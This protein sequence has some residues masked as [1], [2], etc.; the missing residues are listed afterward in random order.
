MAA[1]KVRTANNDDLTEAELLRIADQLPGC[2]V[3]YVEL[4]GGEPLVSPHFR[5]V[6]KRLSRRHVRVTRILTNGF[7][8]D[9]ALFDFLSAQGQQPQIVISF[10]GLDTHNWQRNHPHAQERAVAAMHRTVARGFALRCAVQVNRHTL[11]RL[12]ETC[13]FLKDLGAQSLFLIRTSETPRW[14]EN[15]WVDESLPF[16]DYYDACC[17]VAQTAVLENWGVEIQVFNGFDL[18]FDPL[19]ALAQKP[20]CSDVESCFLRCGRAASSFFIA[21]TGRV[22]PC[23]AFEGIGMAGGFFDGASLKDLSLIH[24]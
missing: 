7:L 2:G 5:A 9:D 8:V 20:A 12:A 4:T 23:D 18:Y 16:D 10:D 11:P 22:W 1:D 6:V 17:G 24:I 14:S 3:Q 19:P 13:A 21:H 15:A